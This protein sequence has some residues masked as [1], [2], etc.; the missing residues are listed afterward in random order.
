MVHKMNA[1]ER[2]G[3]LA[4]LP[5]GRVGFTLGLATY[6][7]VVQKLVQQINNKS[8]LVFSFLRQLQTSKVTE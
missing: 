1:H 7:P 3:L 6:F 2:S 4:Q 5:E 8:I